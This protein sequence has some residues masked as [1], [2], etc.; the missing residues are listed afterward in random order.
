MEFLWKVVEVIIDNRLRSSVCLHNALHGFCTGRVMGTTILELKL[1][2]ELAIM[3]QDPMFLVFL[4]LCKACNTVDHGH[5][6]T[7]LDG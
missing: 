6:L 3:Y 1:A 4:D 5:Y 2:Q 7:T